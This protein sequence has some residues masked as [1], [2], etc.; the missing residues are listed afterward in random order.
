LE[1]GVL[2]FKLGHA[3][4]ARKARQVRRVSKAQKAVPRTYSPLRE[5]TLFAN[6]YQIIQIV[7]TILP[8]VRTTIKARRVPAAIALRFQRISTD[9]IAVINPK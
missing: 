1:A 2:L 3:L 6:S 5:N 4:I 7:I 8:I 9:N